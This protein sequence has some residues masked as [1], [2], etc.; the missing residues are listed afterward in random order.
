LRPRI[1]IAK[2]DCE[3]KRVHLRRAARSE[4]R[5]LSCD[6]RLRMKALSHE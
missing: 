2:S 4:R 1:R 3:I 5:C 6:E